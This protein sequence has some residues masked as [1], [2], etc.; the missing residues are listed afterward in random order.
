MTL[1]AS[2]AE[3]RRRRISHQTITSW[4]AFTDEHSGRRPPRKIDAHGVDL[5][6]AAKTLGRVR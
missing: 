1:D 5:V 4:D 6:R 3:V 2:G